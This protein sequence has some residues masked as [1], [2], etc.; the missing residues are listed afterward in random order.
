MMK[1]NRGQS[2]IEVVIAIGILGVA[3]IG[4]V[5]AATVGLKTARVSRERAFA[6]VLVDRKIERIRSVKESDPQA[7]FNLGSRTETE[8]ET[9]DP[10]YTI[11]T[12]YTSQLAGQRMLI[13]VIVTWVDGNLNYSV[14]QSTYLR[15]E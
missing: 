11:L 15:K 14:N 8:T 10:G 1:K 4:I 12:T 6:R 7:F 3:L 5:S 9:T 2:L 13:E